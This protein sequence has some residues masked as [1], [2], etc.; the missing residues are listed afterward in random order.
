MRERQ[1]KDLQDVL[2]ERVHLLSRA[3]LPNSPRDVLVLPE[4]LTFSEEIK[5]TDYHIMMLR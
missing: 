4:G 2:Q 1:L 3:D 5:K